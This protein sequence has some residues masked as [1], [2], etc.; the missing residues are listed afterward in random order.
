MFGRSNSE[1]VVARKNGQVTVLSDGVVG[2]N[3]MGFSSDVVGAVMTKSGGLDT[4]LC[5]TVEGQVF[6]VG[7]DETSPV[8]V[9][10]RPV[11][12]QVEKPVECFDVKGV[13]LAI[14]GKENRL[15]VWNVETKQKV[16]EAR[17]PPD[18]WLCLK[19]PMWISG[20][21]FVSSVQDQDR[22]VIVTKHRDLQ[23]FDFAPEHDRRPVWKSVIGE[24]PLN[25]VALSSNCSEIYC[26]NVTGFVF[27]VD[28]RTGKVVGRMT[29]SCAG[30]VR[31][32]CCVGKNLV[33]AVGLDRFVYGYDAKLRT[34]VH[35]VYAKQRLCKV[36]AVEGD[37]V[38]AEQAVQKEEEEE[39][40]EDDDDDEA[41][42]GL[43][44]ARKREKEEE[45]KGGMERECLPEGGLVHGSVSA[46]L[47]KLKSKKQRVKR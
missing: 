9:S 7:V 31:D 27:A 23:M 13:L 47:M 45:Q 42:L 12:L 20:V 43:E 18:D 29:P 32:I 10:S 4:L 33:L 36:L 16:F 5:V 35:K 37:Q 25:C 30:S 15:R 41:W 26:G 6:L 39:E 2:L 21:K 34:S 3:V 44:P 22:V 17:N 8:D 28:A 24:E 40:E 11:S 38:D 19:V 46:S 14:G 1:I